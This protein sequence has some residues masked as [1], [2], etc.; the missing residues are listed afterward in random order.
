MMGWIANWA[1]RH[2]ATPEA[3][4][5]K[6]L[7]D[8][9]LELFRAEQNVLDAQ[10]RADYYRTRLS[11]LEDVVQ[12]GIERVVDQRTSRQ[13]PPPLRVSPKLSAAQ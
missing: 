7:G 2:A 5:Q 11:F 12:A 8:M 3:L 1:M 10:M 9:R 13:T 4:A 6:A